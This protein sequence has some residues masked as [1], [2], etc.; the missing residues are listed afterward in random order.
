MGH[1][2]SGHATPLGSSCCPRSPSRW[3]G[4]VA[5]GDATNWAHHP[6]SGALQEPVSGTA[7]TAF[8]CLGSAPLVCRQNLTVHRRPALLS[9]RGGRLPQGR[10][11][12]AG[13]PTPTAIWKCFFVRIG[14]A[15]AGEAERS[16]GDNYAVSSTGTRPYRT[17]RRLRDRYC[18]VAVVRGWL[19][20][21]RWSRCSRTWAA[22]AGV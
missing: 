14:R 8:D 13:E 18:E 22:S 10:T 21:M 15:S 1:Q 16:T 3:T 2:A 4:W 11:G 5:L 20:V 19:P 6:L 7:I 9:N 17:V 12:L